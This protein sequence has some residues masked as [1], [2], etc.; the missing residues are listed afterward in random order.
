[1][2]IP[3]TPKFKETLAVEKLKLKVPQK[4]EKNDKSCCPVG[5]NSEWRRSSA[6]MSSQQF[7]TSTISLMN[8]CQKQGESIALRTNVF[9]HPE[10]KNNAKDKKLK[11]KQIKFVTSNIISTVEISAY[12]SAYN[13]KQ[14]FS[15]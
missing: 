4:R 1:L 6:Q 2:W 12:T 13:Y 8:N 14:Y 9:L 10:Y 15:E 7:I 5:G 3:Y 11:T